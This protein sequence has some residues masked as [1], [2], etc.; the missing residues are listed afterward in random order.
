MIFLVA[1]WKK[2]GRRFRKKTSAR[3][4]VKGRGRKVQTD[5]TW[6]C[7]DLQMIDSISEW[8]DKDV[9]IKAR[10]QKENDVYTVPIKKNSY[11]IQQQ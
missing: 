11:D 7:K 1:F 6:D 2:L 3:S 9:A 4:D 10:Y 8:N 5:I